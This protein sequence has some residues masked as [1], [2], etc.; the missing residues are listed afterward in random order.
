MVTYIYLYVSSICIVILGASFTPH[1]RKI[2]LFRVVIIDVKF[3]VNSLREG[4]SSLIY[5]KLSK[6]VSEM[7][8]NNAQHL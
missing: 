8:Q 5:S 2:P 3:D 6:E 1:I 7:Q 4:V